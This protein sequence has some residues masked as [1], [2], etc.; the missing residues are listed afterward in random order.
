MKKYILDFKIAESTRL[1]SNYGLLKLSPVN[2]TIPETEGGQFA[3]VSVP[4]SKGTYLRRPISLCNVENGLLW[5]LI[6]NA[7]E[8]TDHLINMSE[9]EI[10]NLVL[11]LGNGFS[12]P[13]DKNKLTLLVGGGVGVAPLLYWGRILKEK[14]YNFAFLL[15]AKSEKDLLLLNEFEKLSK[16]YISTD[17]GSKGEKGLVIFNSILNSPEIS[18]I[19]SC[20]PLPMMKGIAKIAAEKKINCEVSLENSMACGIGA[21]LCCVED[22][23]DN[24]NVCVCKEGPVFNIKKLK[25]EILK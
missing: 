4:N 11:P 6:R 15:A 9:G 16:V 8:G 7:G 22:T 24:G 1:S 20:G 13:E 14:G 18:H 2:G 19:S 23:K 3:Q 5:L 17:D 10:I 12:L 25:W 21:C